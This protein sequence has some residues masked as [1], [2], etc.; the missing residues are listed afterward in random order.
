MGLWTPRKEKQKGERDGNGREVEK[1]KELEF[2]KDSKE[3]PFKYV[4][5][6]QMRIRSEGDGREEREGTWRSERS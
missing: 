1:G 3:D 4:Q 6:E 5:G 2:R